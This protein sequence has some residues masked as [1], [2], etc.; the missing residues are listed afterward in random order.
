MRNMNDKDN[1][2]IIVFNVMSKYETNLF[3]QRCQF[4]INIVKK[5][6]HTIY[7]DTTGFNLK[8]VYT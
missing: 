4:I 8:Q 3:M 7:K 2:V 6:N 1:I 5:W